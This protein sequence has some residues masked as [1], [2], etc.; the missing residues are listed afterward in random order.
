MTE[1]VSGWCKWLSTQLLAERVGGSNASRGTPEDRPDHLLPKGVKVPRNFRLLEELEE[2]QKGVGD[3][4]VSWGLEDDEDMTLTRWTGM[5]IGPPRTIYENRIY[6]LK[7]E[8][9]PKYPEA[10]PFVR[11]VTKINM[12]GVNSSNGVVD[13]RAISVLAKWQNSYSIKVVL[14]ELR[15]LMMSKE[16]M[17]LPQPPEGQCYSN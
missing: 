5:I 6:S 3:G 10:P 12:N 4:T 2:G 14:Q 7:I 13:P 1:G 15:R 9:G 16:N 17:K 11:F 8:C